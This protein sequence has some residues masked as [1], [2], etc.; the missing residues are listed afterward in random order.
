MMNRLKKK[1]WFAFFCSWLQYFK[2]QKYKKFIHSNIINLLIW[3]LSFLY[4]NNIIFE[5]KNLSISFLLFIFGV[6]TV[7]S[8]ME[9]LIEAP[10]PYTLSKRFP[11]NGIDILQ[12]RLISK[13]SLPAEIILLGLVI[14]HFIMHEYYGSVAKF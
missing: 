5:T 12:M 6:K 11:L 9:S 3:V 14:S 4:F 1:I 10:I 2:E 13:Y 8:S 7:L